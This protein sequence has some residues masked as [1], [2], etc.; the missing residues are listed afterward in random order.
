MSYPWPHCQ[1]EVHISGAGVPFISNM[2]FKKHHKE[3]NIVPVFRF[4]EAKLCTIEPRVQNACGVRLAISQNNLQERWL[5]IYP[6][7]LHVTICTRS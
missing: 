5:D 2:L 3:V 6:L 4:C 1:C 7:C